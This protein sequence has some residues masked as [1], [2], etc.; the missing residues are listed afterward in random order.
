MVTNQV[1]RGEEWI[2]GILPTV[3][4]PVKQPVPATNFL[5]QLLIVINLKCVNS[6]AQIL[7]LLPSPAQ[8]TVIPMSNSKYG[9]VP[10]GSPVAYQQRPQEATNARYYSVSWCTTVSKVPP[11][12][13]ATVKHSSLQTAL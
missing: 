1:E 9:E 3:Y 8:N 2:E 6:D 10:D 7:N 5:K 4:C 13:A 12:R 11:S